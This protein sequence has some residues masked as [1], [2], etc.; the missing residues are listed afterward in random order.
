MTGVTVCG[1]RAVGCR[2]RMAHGDHCQGTIMRGRSLG[3]ALLLAIAA[4]PC[5]ARDIRATSFEESATVPLNGLR[6][7]LAGVSAVE[8]NYLSFYTVGLYVP[9]S[10]PDPH[11]LARGSAA[12]R[13][14]LQWV[15]PKVSA[16]AAKTYW[17]EEFAR[18]IGDAQ[19]VAHL[20]AAIARFVSAAAP[21]Q[22]GDVMLIDYDP[23]SG[24]AL[25][26][27]A[28]PPV[29]FAGVEFARALLGIWFG[30][31]A[32]AERRDELLGRIETSP[33]KL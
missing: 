30:D 4:T 17:T 16:E 31:R 25:T 18:S 8:R 9:K 14:A 22:K 6:M 33:P 29:R 5:I 12:C 26:R 23:E 28:N 11:E 2:V 19:G 27:N 15:A 10:N 21:V 3:L 13:I 32:P 7:G 24:L 1:L 20:N